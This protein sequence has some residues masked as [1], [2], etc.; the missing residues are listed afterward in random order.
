M[1]EQF[2]ESA[3]KAV[4]FA[5]GLGSELRRRQIG[6][7]FLL[8]GIILEGKGPGFL[9]LTDAGARL[10]VLQTAFLRDYRGIGPSP[11]DRSEEP[12]A[13][14]REIA[15][16]PD[17]QRA[18]DA[19]RS[20][21]DSSGS[22]SV[23]SAHLLLALLNKNNSSACVLLR[24]CSL[25]VNVVKEKASARLGGYT[26]SEPV[27]EAS[28]GPVASERGSLK[29][30][31]EFGRCLND[32]ALEG[33]LDPVI[34]RS[35]EIARV[36]QIL[37]RRRKNNP[38]L[39][40]EPG[41][42]KTAIAEGL[43]QLIVNG[44]VPEELAGK[45]IFEIGMGSLLAGTKNR[46]S[47]EERLKGIM[48][49]C[50]QAG[51]IILFVDEI[52]T[53]VGAGA[54]SGSMDAANFFKPGLARG[55]LCCIG[56]TTLSEYRQYIEG[57]AAFERRLQPVLV[58]EPSVEDTVA[59]L[60]GLRFRYEQH[61]KRVISDRALA[62]AAGLAARY[63]GD[64]FLPDKAIDLMDEALSRHNRVAAGFAK[65]K[66]QELLLLRRT[67]MEAVKEQDF[68]LAES[69]QRQEGIFLAGLSEEEKAACLVSEKDVAQVISDWTGIPLT[70]LDRSE[71][72][73]LMNLEKLLHE[74]VIGQDEAV[75][76]LSAALRRARS[77]LKDPKRPAGS[78]I[79]LGPTGVGKT[80]LVKALAAVFYGSA[81]AFVRFDM[82]EFMESHSVSKL[83][84]S[85]PGYVGFREGGQ[86]T[87]AVRRKPWSVILFDEIEKAH[88][89]VFDLMLQLLED[90]RITD[91]QGH[92]VDCRNTLIVMTSNLG[93]AAISKGD[94]G[95]LG[96][97][98]ATAAERA[99]AR[100][101][102]V[103]E[104][105][106]EAA[107]DLFRPEFLNRVDGL[108]VFNPLDQSEVEQIVPLM[109]AEI[110]EQLR[111]KW[112]MRLELSPLAAK[113]LALLGYDR[114]YG[115]RPLRRKLRE[116]VE[117]PLAEA[118]LRQE[119]KR[120]DSIVVDFADGKFTFVS[121][122]KQAV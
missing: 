47:F 38:V 61:H 92:T 86:L 26:N 102:R 94:G 14:S 21:A 88:P 34:G 43:A 13:P 10:H 72:E 111:E 53:L 52:H 30:L 57:D 20:L 113:Q 50:K 68:A 1:F 69:L 39:I 77:G 109:I 119:F 45:L 51:N 55:E 40:G 117:D 93:A 83:I 56:A 101:A 18:F 6:T 76:D 16:S 116:L 90:G 71:R 46:G 8:L 105:V 29:S 121:S 15:F 70:A 108:V 106:M 33:K 107:K 48:A 62:A 97:E 60:Q 80:E 112:D 9:A 110:N 103:R 100:Q 79:F 99:V 63:I 17:A 84:G 41:T 35:N 3:L 85:P 22:P 64:R 98:I 81:D 36:I 58:V 19:A 32:L 89:K 75:R 2:S 87:E 65:D 122:V 114:V 91:A 66:V 44:Q 78:F 24:K 11:Q 54:P 74:R 59:I 42:G 28:A 4:S 96:F 95:G 118:I 25:N 12:L 104:K 37:G 115:A 23:T 82:S 27:A 120:G 49:E 31:K 67:K 5:Q 7:D 73:R